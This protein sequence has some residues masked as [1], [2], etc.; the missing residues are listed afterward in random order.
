MVNFKLYLYFPGGLVGVGG[1]VV[2]IKLKANL[3]SNWTGL[4]LELSLAKAILTTI[5]SISR[6][7]TYKRVQAVK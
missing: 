6:V 7:L 4:G 1:W 2:I 5:I 3:S